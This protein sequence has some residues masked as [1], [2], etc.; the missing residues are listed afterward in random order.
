MAKCRTGMIVVSLP[1]AR[2][3][4]ASYALIRLRAVCVVAGFDNRTCTVSQICVDVTEGYYCRSR[5]AGRC[6]TYG[7]ARCK[8]W[9]WQR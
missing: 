3:G 1:T 5:L 4:G 8:K 2:L 9:K 7:G 6:H